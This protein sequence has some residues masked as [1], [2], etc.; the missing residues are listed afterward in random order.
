LSRKTSRGEI[1]RP[2]VRALFTTVMA[3][4]LSPPAWKKSVSASTAVPGSV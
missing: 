2:R 4:M 1:C 3:T